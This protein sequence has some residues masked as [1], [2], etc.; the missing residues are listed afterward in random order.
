MDFDR[1]HYVYEDGEGSEFFETFIRDLALADWT[2]EDGYVLRV[3]EGGVDY[4]IDASLGKLEIYRLAEG[5]QR[6]SLDQ[7][8]VFTGDLPQELTNKL[9]GRYVFS[10]GKFHDNLTGEDHPA[11]M[12]E[13][14]TGYFA[15]AMN[16]N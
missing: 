6:L 16:V 2:I 11:K 14:S 13:S 3:S 8:R 9:E 7:R 10:K 1:V 5:S 15:N 12:F 4:E